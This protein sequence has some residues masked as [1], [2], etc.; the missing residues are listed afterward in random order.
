MKIENY[1]KPERCDHS[2]RRDKSIYVQFY[3]PYFSLDSPFKGTHARYSIVR[4]S[5]F[6]AS[7]NNRQGRGPEFHKL[8]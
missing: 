1:A 4:F 3:P 2:P 6:F 7:I 5:Q 8:C